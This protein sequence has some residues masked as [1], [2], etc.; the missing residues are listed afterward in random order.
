MSTATRN[1]RHRT[2]PT[3]FPHF[4]NVINELLNT[5]VGDVLTHKN[6]DYTTPLVNVVEH[7]SEYILQMMVPSL[8]KSDVNISIDKNVLSIS[9]DKKD[10]TE[11]KFKI[12]EFKYGVFKRSFKLPETVD[13]SNISA[14]LEDG[15]LFL[16][17]NKKAKK[18]LEAKKIEIK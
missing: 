4:G 7:K 12:R 13:A 11:A 2:R 5:S 8:S 1:R 18:D 6:V 15:V 9:A 16:T 10:E 17:L 3:A 14:K